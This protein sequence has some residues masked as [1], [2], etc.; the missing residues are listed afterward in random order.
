MGRVLAQA[1]AEGMMS[2]SAIGADKTLGQKAATP[3]I[4]SWVPYTPRKPGGSCEGDRCPM[5]PRGL[6]AVD[7]PEGQGVGR[8]LPPPPPPGHGG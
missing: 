5:P 4:V 7:D 8:R 3:G 2:V 6:G 1:S